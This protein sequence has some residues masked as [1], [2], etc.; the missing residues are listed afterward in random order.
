MDAPLGRHLIADFHGCD[1]ALLADPQYIAAALE[2]AALAGRATVLQRHFHHFGPQ[3]GVTGMLLLMESH[4]S[5]HSWP[6][7]GYAAIDLF[8]CGQAESDAALDELIRQLQPLRT[9]LQ[10]I[11]RGSSRLVASTGPDEHE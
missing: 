8:M 4:I 9:S 11:L 10:R 2:A 1:A 6:E 7:H 3:Q 5:I